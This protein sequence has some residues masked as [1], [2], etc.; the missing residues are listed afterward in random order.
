MA[1]IETKITNEAINKSTNGSI[2]EIIETGLEEKKIEEKTE[3]KIESKTEGK[4]PKFV[5]KREI[6][7]KAEK[8]AQVREL[9]KS[10]GGT[11]TFKEM[12]DWLNLLTP[13]MWNR[14]Y[15]YLYR[16]FPV[17]VRQLSNP[18]NPNYIDVLSEP[19]TEQT[20]REKHG[21][22]K[23]S[24][25]VNDVDKFNTNKAKLFDAR[26]Q[27][28]L[29]E[30]PPKISNLI[31]VDR[32]AR[33]NIGY[34]Q[35][36]NAQGFTDKDGKPIDKSKGSE[37]NLTSSGETQV[38]MMKLMMD[39]F[40]QMTKDKQNE[41]KKQLGGEEALSKSIGDIL[42][43]RMK[44]DDPNKMVNTFTGMMTAINSTK[45]PTTDGGIATIMPIFVQM[46]QMQSDNMK[47][48]MQMQSDNSKALVEAIKSNKE[49]GSGEG[50]SGGNSRI[51]E[52]KELLEI[53]DMIKGGSTKKSTTEIIADKIGDAI[54]PVLNIVG[55]IVALNA[56]QKQAAGHM[57]Q[58]VSVAP[59]VS[60]QPG[61]PQ[62]VTRS[63]PT[64]M[65]SIT[66]KA[67]EASE[68]SKIGSPTTSS[69][70]S[71]ENVSEKAILCQYLTQ[72]S[73][74][75]LQ[76]L[77][78]PGWEFAEKVE[79]MFGKMVVVTIKKYGKDKI[80]SASKEIP[81]FWKAVSGT[82]GE[83]YVDKWFDEFCRYEEI[84][85]AMEDEDGDMIEKE[86]ERGKNND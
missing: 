57:P 56:A 66:D 53:A 52:L 86:E 29:A 61:Q 58:G 5:N 79:Q 8:L 68:Q 7:T 39:F 9:P 27:I 12:M 77:G 76:H 20:I 2:D 33:E 37:M 14:M 72:F 28:P 35:W 60:Q 73:P 32:S 71:S 84:I 65:T 41:I 25:W 21:G 6:D 83:E 1:K 34:V 24:F 3:G 42:L 82:Y 78:N 49:S 75:I 55:N 62:I 11:V 45:S 64:G 16:T 85:E 30:Y 74:L 19:F 15:I 51:S 44:Q 17:I 50:G 69:V 80:V 10:P 63:L 40:S 38:A 48:M 59:Q 54:T 67:S 13:Q 70:D 46:M 31:E 47:V 81:E 18:E 26:L 22:G 43:E 36:L 4:E 23:Y